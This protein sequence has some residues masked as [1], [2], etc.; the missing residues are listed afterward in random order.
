M[1]IK[2][3]LLAPERGTYVVNAAFTDEDGTSVV[4]DTLTW[5]LFDASGATVNSRAGINIASP[6]VN[7]DILLSGDDLDIDD[8][9]ER[10]LLI[11]GTY[12]STLGVGLPLH[13]QAVF[14]VED[15]VGLT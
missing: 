10:Y 3:T 8:G 6:A 2:L 5:S 1:A 12:T 14:G 15:F 4:P 7:V 13:D 9:K 11:K